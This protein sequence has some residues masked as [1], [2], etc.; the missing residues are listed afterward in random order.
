MLPLNVAIDD[1]FENTP[2]FVTIE[3]ENMNL[4]TIPTKLLARKIHQNIFKNDHISERQKKLLE[5]LPG[6]K[7]DNIWALLLKQ[8]CRPMIKWFLIKIWNGILFL[9]EK[10]IACNQIYN[11]LSTLHFF[12]CKIV[13]L[14]IRLLLSRSIQHSLLLTDPSVSLSVSPEYFLLLFAIYSNLMKIHFQEGSLRFRDF[15]FRVKISWKCEMTR[16]DNAFE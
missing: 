15:F 9:P 3:E 2:L 10:C 5:A 16:R 7:L 14:T 11:E 8:K 4:D 6:I 13:K 12:H 1:I